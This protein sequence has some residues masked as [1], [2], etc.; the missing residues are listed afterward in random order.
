[1]LEILGIP[2]RIL[3][4]NFTVR[5]SY[6][7]IIQNNFLNNNNLIQNVRKEKGKEKK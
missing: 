6:Y 5:F 3:I 2:P 4:F 1:M 7:E